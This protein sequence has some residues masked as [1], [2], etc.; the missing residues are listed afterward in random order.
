MEEFFYP[1]AC[2]QLVLIGTASVAYLL[3]PYHFKEYL[4]ILGSTIIL[5][6]IQYTILFNNINKTI[7]RVNNTLEQRVRE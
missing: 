3:Y 6:L 7:A 2:I 5:T 1:L 4:I